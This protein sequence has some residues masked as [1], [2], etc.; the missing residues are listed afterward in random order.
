LE[1]GIN[2]GATILFF[3]EGKKTPSIVKSKS[4]GTFSSYATGHRHHQDAL[5]RIFLNPPPKGNENG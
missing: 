2:H 4:D 1:K 3:G 5:E